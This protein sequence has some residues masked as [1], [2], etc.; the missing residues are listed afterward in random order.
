MWFSISIANIYDLKMTH[1][2]IIWSLFPVHF[3]FVSLGVFPA[4]Y[5]YPTG[6]NYSIWSQVTMRNIKVC[7]FLLVRSH[8]INSTEMIPF[9]AL[10]QRREY[11][12]T[13]NTFPANCFIEIDTCTTLLIIWFKIITIGL[14][15]VKIRKYGFF[16]T[17]KHLYE[18]FKI[19]VLCI[20]PE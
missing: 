6:D 12:K 10:A 19:S 18:Q 9:G 4:T 1:I 11:C 2:E 3:A 13:N 5:F 17:E 20:F 16:P 14:Q 7:N 15:K 8:S